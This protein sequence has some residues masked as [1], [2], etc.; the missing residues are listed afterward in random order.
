[1]RTR[2]EIAVYVV[3]FIALYINWTDVP[4]QRLPVQVH[5]TLTK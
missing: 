3:L 4:K 1:M 5:G 2:I